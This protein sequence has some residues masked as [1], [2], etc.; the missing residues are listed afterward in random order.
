MKDLMKTS[1]VRALY[2]G[3]S[4]PLKTLLLA[5]SVRAETDGHDGTEIT[6]VELKD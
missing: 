2:C 6:F 4:E 3:L 5:E 1:W